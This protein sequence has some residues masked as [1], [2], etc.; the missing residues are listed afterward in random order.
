MINDVQ[1]WT[2]AAVLR[3]AKSCE[4][5]SWGK[6]GNWQVLPGWYGEGMAEGNDGKENQSCPLTTS[7]SRIRNGM[8]WIDRTL[9]LLAA[10]MFI[11]VVIA[12]LRIFFRGY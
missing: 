10:N 11:L 3:T 9:I 12:Q 5:Q 7:T 2:N 1:G 6:D 4:V 8:W